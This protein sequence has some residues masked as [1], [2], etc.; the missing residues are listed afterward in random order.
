[1]HYTGMNDVKQA[2]THTAESHYIIGPG[3]GP[4][5]AP[6]FDTH[7]AVCLLSQQVRELHRTPHRYYWKM[8]K[9]AKTKKT[10]CVFAQR[11]LPEDKR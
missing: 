3:L 7:T 6:C 5:N 1:M 11:F 10:A 9:K 2:G 4:F 8:K